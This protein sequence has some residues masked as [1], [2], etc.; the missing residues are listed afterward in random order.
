MLLEQH[1]ESLVDPIYGEDRKKYLLNMF[2][3]L[4]HARSNLYN[5]TDPV[6]KKYNFRD[7]RGG[8]FKIGSFI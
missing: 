1:S 5:L 3:L 6:L 7:F 2:P 4:F 8:Q